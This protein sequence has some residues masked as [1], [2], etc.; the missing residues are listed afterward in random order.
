MVWWIEI[1]S[2][3]DFPCPRLMDNIRVWEA[4]VDE[5]VVN[6]VLVQYLD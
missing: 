1:R 6:T 5:E 4:K 2:G 3:C